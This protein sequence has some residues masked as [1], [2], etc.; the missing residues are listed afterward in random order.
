M[1]V[2]TKDLTLKEIERICEKISCSKC[3][4]NVMDV[5]AGGKICFFS[6]CVFPDVNIKVEYDENG[7]IN[8]IE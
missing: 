2:S 8:F 6:S 5:Y 1:I 3:P 7:D 4:F